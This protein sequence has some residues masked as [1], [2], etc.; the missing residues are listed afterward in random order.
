MNPYQIAADLGEKGKLEAGWKIVNRLLIENPLDVQALVTGSYIM[1]RLGVLPTAY[2]FALSATQLWPKDS[3][4]WTNLGH[5]ASEMWLVEESEKCYHRALEVATR[6]DH[7]KV[8]WLNLSALYLDNGR[9]REAE[10]LTRKI[11]A[12]DPDHKNAQANLGFC[13]LAQRNWAEGWKGYHNT[14]GSD[15][16]PKVQYHGEPEWDGTPGKTVALYADQGLGDEVSFAS[17]LPD[18]IKDC[19]RVILDCDDRLEGLFKRSFPKAKVYGT[20]RSKD[21][22]WDKE[23]WNIDAS[24]PLGQI[25]EYYRTDDSHFSGEP[26]LVPCP[27]RL[28]MWRALFKGKKKPVIG[29]AWTGGIPKT[30][31][32]NRRI[33]LE[34]LLPIFRRVS[35]HYVSLQYKDAQAEIDAFKAKHKWV[36][37]EQ[38]KFGTLTNDYDDT[39]AMIAACDFVICIQTAVA[40]TAGALGVPVYVLVPTATQWRYGESTETIPWYKSL[41][42]IRQTK[43][44]EWTD[45]ID[46]LSRRLQADYSRVPAGAGDSARN[47]R[48][49]DCLNPV[50]TNGVGHHQPDGRHASA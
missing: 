6:D 32:R 13:Q 33:A 41:R 21:A 1:R 10:E 12:A 5:A 3:A 36:D 26:Y 14:I 25:G 44:G 18:A 15:W 45:D 20:R 31:S 16:R 4:A 43:G 8:L 27:N 40:H 35:G 34:D 19:K 37:L 50:R 23:D 7:K 11:L 9:F 39:A 48:V 29:I 24:L 2:H 49:R 38:Y 42:V 47:D 30:N 28:A 22:K 17:M 46:R